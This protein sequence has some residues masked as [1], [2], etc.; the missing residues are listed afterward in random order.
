[1]SDPYY[2]WYP[3]DYQRDTNDLSLIEHGAYRVLLDE[4]YTNKGLPSDINR[5]YRICKAMTPDEQTA[6]RTV[7]KRFFPENGNG[8]LCNGRADKEILKRDAFLS[9]QGRKSALGVAARGLSKKQ[10]VG[11]PAGQPL[12]SPSP[13]PSLT[14][15]LS[16]I[17]NLFVDTSDEVRLASY[18]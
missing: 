6:V 5:L 12:P 14:P 17:K 1:M 10:P 9:E 2:P 7:A 15:S 11:S 3:G 18:L 8:A 4:Y 13:S 16:P